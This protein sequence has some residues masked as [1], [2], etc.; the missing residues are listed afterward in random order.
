MGVINTGEEIY[1]LGKSLGLIFHPINPETQKPNP[2][3]W[4][5]SNHPV[6]RGEDN[7]K[8]WVV[9]SKQVQNEIMALAYAHKD[10][11]V[12]LDETGTVVETETAVDDTLSALAEARKKL[13]LLNV[14]VE[15]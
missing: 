6:I 2:Q 10:A 12:Q 8:T 4:K 14:D 9:G 15:G 3:M 1:D 11:A 13:E 7:V 5:F